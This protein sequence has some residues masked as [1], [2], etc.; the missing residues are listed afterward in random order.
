[1]V[2]VTCKPPFGRG[3]PT[4]AIARSHVI[5]SIPRNLL[6]SVRLP[7][8]REEES[9]VANNVLPKADSLSPRLLGM[10]TS[11]NIPSCF[12]RRSDLSWFLHESVRRFGTSRR[13]RLP[14]RATRT[15]PVVLLRAKA[16]LFAP[17]HAQPLDV[18]AHEAF[19]KLEI[20][21][22]IGRRS[23]ELRFQVLVEPQ[24]RRI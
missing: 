13:V 6:M 10:T 3:L 16:A 24:Q 21:A 8:R 19:D 15:A 5:P 7:R 20:V 9:A 18:L 23:H 11:S 12:L 22:T 17:I 1:S 2:G 4:L 14:L